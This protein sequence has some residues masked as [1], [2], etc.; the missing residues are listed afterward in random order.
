M[1]LT[2]LPSHVNMGRD[3]LHLSLA[4]NRIGAVLWEV[5]FRLVETLTGREI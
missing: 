2:D 5:K 4:G 3:K 1:L